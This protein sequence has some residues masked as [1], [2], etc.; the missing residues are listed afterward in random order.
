LLTR[1][2]TGIF[3]LIAILALPA[4]AQHARPTKPRAVSAPPATPA[5]ITL[6][7]GQLTVDAR[8]SGL[9]QILQDIASLTGMSITGLAGGKPI[10]GVYGP[11]DPRSVV[12]SLL[13]S[14]GNN[15][16]LVG[17]PGLPRQ[18]VLTPQTPPP[19]APAQSKPH[20]ADVYAQQYAELE[21]GAPY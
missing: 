7:N 1:R 20:P 10:F 2:L 16:L 9:N 19:P 14:S 13:Q 15:F 12:T 21:S 4:A 8:N 6:A 18:L 3:I 5:R 17:P 11:G